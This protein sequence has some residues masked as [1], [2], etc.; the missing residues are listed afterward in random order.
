MSKNVKLLVLFLVIV[1]GLILVAGYIKKDDFPFDDK[2]PRPGS[3]IIHYYVN[4]TNEADIE[5]TV[6]VFFFNESGGV[7]AMVHDVMAPGN[8]SEHMLILEEGDYTWE[9]VATGCM[10]EQTLEEQEY[11][12]VSAGVLYIHLSNTGMNA[13]WGPRYVSPF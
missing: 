8:V 6:G 10:Y 4:I 11:I 3:D 1:F 5:I 12:D 7:E 13:T 2:E 9:I